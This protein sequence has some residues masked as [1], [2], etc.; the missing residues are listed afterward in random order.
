MWAV[1]D[2]HG[3]LNLVNA[4]CFALS[5]GEKLKEM[6]REVYPRLKIERSPLDRLIDEKPNYGEDWRIKVKPIGVDLLVIVYREVEYSAG[7]VGMYTDD[8]GEMLALFKRSG[9][10]VLGTRDTFKKE[11]ELP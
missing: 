1:K 3:M 6:A 11:L 10:V 7:H 2:Q 9:E 5:D 4:I 8:E